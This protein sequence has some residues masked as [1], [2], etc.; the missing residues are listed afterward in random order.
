M[1]YLRRGS[2]SFDYHKINCITITCDFYNASNSLVSEDK[3]ETRHG[4]SEQQGLENTSILAIKVKNEVGST[5]LKLGDL[6]QMKAQLGREKK[7]RVK[8]EQEA[9]D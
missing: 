4:S 8:F 3:N 7:I 9:A 6:E 5:E 1:P 2:P